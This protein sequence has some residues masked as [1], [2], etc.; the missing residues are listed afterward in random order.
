MFEIRVDTASLMAKTVKMGTQM[1]SQGEKMVK[2]VSLAGLRESVKATPVDTGALAR[3]WQ[4]S[5]I[6]K[7]GNGIKGGYSSN[8]EYV[9]AVNYGWKAYGKGSWKEGHHMIEKGEK[10]MEKATKRIIKKFMGQVLKF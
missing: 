3:S 4:L 9:N 6:S 1:T 8:S 10:A 7:S 5:P 2:E